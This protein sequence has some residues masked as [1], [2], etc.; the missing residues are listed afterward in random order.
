VIKYYFVRSSEISD[1]E[2][3]FI[4]HNIRLKQKAE[5]DCLWHLTVY[6]YGLVS[7]CVLMVAFMVVHH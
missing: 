4:L 5:N 6:K 2:I 1:A 3:L 7:I